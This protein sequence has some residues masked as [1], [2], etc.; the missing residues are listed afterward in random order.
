MLDTKEVNGFVF[1][2]FG[3]LL[4]YPEDATLD[5][6][7]ATKAKLESMGEHI[8]ASRVGHLIMQ[9]VLKPVEDTLVVKGN[10]SGKDPNPQN[11]AKPPQS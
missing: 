3:A 6:L 7:E 8:S 2:A 11:I 4:S 1:D 9:E 10:W 5:L